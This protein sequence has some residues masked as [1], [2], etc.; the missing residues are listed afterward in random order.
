[1][2]D[3]SSDG[4]H[5]PTE[6]LG[7]PELV[8]IVQIADFTSPERLASETPLLQQAGEET[9]TGFARREA[10]MTARVKRLPARMGQ[11]ISWRLV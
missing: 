11:S 4:F 2:P 3:H 9:A 1:M 5:R 10:Q 6:G 7:W 8:Y